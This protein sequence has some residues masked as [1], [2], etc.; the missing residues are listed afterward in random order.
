MPDRYSDAEPIDG[1]AAHRAHCSGWA[2]EDAKGRP[3][4]C[5]RCKPHLRA[6]R[7]P[8]DYAETIPSRR[9]QEAIARADRED[10]RRA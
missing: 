3:R 6:T 7:R 5:L 4:P 1:D 2:G 10:R 9:A 8:H